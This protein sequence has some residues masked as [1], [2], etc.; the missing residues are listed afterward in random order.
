ML[1]EIEIQTLLIECG[2]QKQTAFAKLYRSASPRLYGAAR[3]LLQ[4]SDLADE[5]LQEAF[6]HIWYKAA[7]YDPEKGSAFA[8]MATIVRYRAL[9]IIR[10]EKSQQNR[11]DAMATEQDILQQGD[12]QLLY[13]HN[14]DEDQQLQL[15]QECLQGLDINQRNSVLMSY[16]YGYSHSE[17]VDRLKRPLGTIKSWIRRG[18]ES[19]RECMQQ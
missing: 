2:K 1:N 14:A 16:Y 17:M 4:N 3:R 7:E 13:D 6:V 19:V 10:R 18:M 11:S 12:E 8:W 5:A 15:L 9:D